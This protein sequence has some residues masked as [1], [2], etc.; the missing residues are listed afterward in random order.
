MPSVERQIRRDLES[1]RLWGLEIFENEI[2]GCLGPFANEAAFPRDLRE[3]PIERNAEL[4]RWLTRKV[5]MREMYLE[6]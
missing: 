3:I 1:N 4:L 5:H 2:V 6:R